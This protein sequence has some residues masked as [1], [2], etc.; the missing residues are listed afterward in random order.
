LGKWKAIRTLGKHTMQ[1]KLFNLEE[2][3]REEQNVAEANPEVVFRIEA[4]M[5]AARTTPAVERFKIKV[6]GD[7]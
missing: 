1:M 6:L 3:L 2:D 4:I 7:K 5:Q